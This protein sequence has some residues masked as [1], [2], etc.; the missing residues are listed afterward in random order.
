MGW[1]ERV[2]TH[3]LGWA[4]AHLRDGLL[5]SF[6]NVAW[7]GSDHAF[8]LDTKTRAEYQRRGIATRVVRLAIDHARSA[9]CTWL[10]VEFEDERRLAPF[11]F[12]ACGF[13]PT[14]AGLIH[15]PSVDR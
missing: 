13:R 4:T 3:S 11:Y 7:D 10:H 14:P 1:W 15:L 5:V 12:G 8:L 2:R 9:G 6:V